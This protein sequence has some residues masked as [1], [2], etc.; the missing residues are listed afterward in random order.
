M[1]EESSG[2]VRR[3]LAMVMVL[4]VVSIPLWLSCRATETRNVARSAPAEPN[5]SASEKA[6]TK[7][8]PVARRA[9]TS[10]AVGFKPSLEMKENVDFLLTPALIVQQA[11][12]G[13]GAIIYPSE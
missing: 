6:A 3:H 11:V 10:V 7:R 2:R 4:L 8:D 9:A 5:A 1:L 13:D 12:S